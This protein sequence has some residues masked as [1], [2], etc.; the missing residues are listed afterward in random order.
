MLLFVFCKKTSTSK[1]NRG[2]FQF[3]A[4]SFP[5]RLGAIG[6]IIPVCPNTLPFEDRKREKKYFIDLRKDKSN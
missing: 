1:T 6:T 3:I 4:G 5:I 2:N